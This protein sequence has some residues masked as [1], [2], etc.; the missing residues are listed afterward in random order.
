M[1]RKIRACVTRKINKFT[2]WISVIS[3]ILICLRM[4]WILLI[5]YIMITARLPLWSRLYSGW[6]CLRLLLFW[7]TCLI[8]K[9]ALAKTSLWG[10]DSSA[11]RNYLRNY[12]SFHVV[13][14]VL[15]WRLMNINVY[16]NVSVTNENRLLLLLVLIYILH[17]IP[18]ILLILIAH[19]SSLELH[20]FD[21]IF[22]P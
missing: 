6:F 17:Q 21:G 5:E 12:L 4:D 8:G 7:R 9:W 2:Y 16:V 18:L 10:C 3:W 20:A 19:S 13:K 15:S 22:L 14:I 1:D 11:I